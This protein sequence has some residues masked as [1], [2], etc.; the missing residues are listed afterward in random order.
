MK[1]SRQ[2]EDMNKTTT[3]TFRRGYTWLLRQ[4]DAARNQIF[5]TK[6]AALVDLEIIRKACPT[7]DDAADFAAGVD[8]ARKIYQFAQSIM[9]RL[10]MFAEDNT[11]EDT[12]DMLKEVLEF[13][14]EVAPEPEDDEFEDPSIE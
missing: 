3:D 4:N 5:S 10:V 8:E 2:G 11:V 9:I 1:Q 14:N 7:G 13:V 12:W 6:K